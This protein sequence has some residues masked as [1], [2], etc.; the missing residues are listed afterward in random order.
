MKRFLG[1]LGLQETGIPLQSYNISPQLNGFLFAGCQL[2]SQRC[3]LEAFLE[4]WVRLLFVR[5]HFGFEFLP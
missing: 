1:C 4:D 2:N 5:S 3:Q